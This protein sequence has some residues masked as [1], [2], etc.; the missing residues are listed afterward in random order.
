MNFPSSKPAYHTL[1]ANAPASTLQPL[2]SLNNQIFAT[3]TSTS[4]P[5]THHS[6]LPEWQ[7][8]LNSP[9]SIIA[10]ATLPTSDNPTDSNSPSLPVGFIFAHPKQHP[11]QSSPA[12]H[13]WLAGVLPAS[14]GTGMFPRLMQMAE[15]H[16]REKGVRMLSVATF[17]AKFEKMYAILTK[18]G[19]EGERDLGEGKVLL[20]K[21][22]S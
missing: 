3:D 10:Y 9:L 7:N 18:T 16:A 21:E 5:S 4:T 8:R 6:S 13:I 11:D 20:F 12:L 17:P 15:G 22:L 19:W 2:L 1:L 14:R